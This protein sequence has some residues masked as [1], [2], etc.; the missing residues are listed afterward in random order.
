MSALG[1]R[2]IACAA[3]LL[4]HIGLAF[5]IPQ[6]RIVGRL[7][8]PIF[9]FLI[10]NGY[11]HTSNPMKY[12]VRL[13]IFAII[14]QLPFMLLCNEPSLFHKGNVFVTLL[15]ALLCI[16]SA[17]ILAKNPKTKWFCLLP[18]MA[19]AVLYLLGYLRSD[20]GVKGICMAMTF[21]LLDGKALWKRICICVFMAASIYS[22]QIIG[23]ILSLL[24]GNGFLF[25]LTR[26]DIRQ[27]WSLLALPLIYV[28]NGKKGHLP[29]GKF[30]AKAAQLGFYAFYPV[31]MLLI[32]FLA[33]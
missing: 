31:H 16:W 29:G 4:D 17:D 10:Y 18:A 9:V 26:W 12:A 33:K 23:C 30:A 21:W 28:Y 5:H 7:A 14:S 11:R 2:I 3:M 32:W 24:R 20:Y 13:A 8:F 15:M 1:L 19:V 25:K 27:L 6:L 22:P